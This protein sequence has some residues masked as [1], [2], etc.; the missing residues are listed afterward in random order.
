M[1]DIPEEFTIMLMIFNRRSNN[2]PTTEIYQV[3]NDDSS[4]QDA[5][6][7]YRAWQMEKES[8]LFQKRR[9]YS[10]WF[11]RGYPRYI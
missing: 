9:Q 6:L 4:Q 8:Y 1:P 5:I 2:T 10:K 3:I 11:I 7:L